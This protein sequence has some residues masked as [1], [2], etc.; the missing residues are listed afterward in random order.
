MTY[1]E[2]TEQPIDKDGLDE[3]IKYS[4]Y[5]VDMHLRYEKPNNAKSGYYII[6]AKYHQGQ[7]VRQ[8]Y[9]QRQSPRNFKNLQRA[10]DWGKKIGFSSICL[11]I[12]YTIY[13]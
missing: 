1:M 6:F 13:P 10:V 12:D 11:N 7:V 4:G 2:P 5:R 3:L 8:V 9:T